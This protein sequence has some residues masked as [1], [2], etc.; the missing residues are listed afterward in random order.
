M[1]V[2][3]KQFPRGRGKGPLHRLLLAVMTAVLALGAGGCGRTQE[4]GGERTGLAFT[5][6]DLEKV[7]QELSAIIE[8]NK[9]KEIRMT[10]RDQEVLYLIRGY[11]EQAT[12]GYSI[13]VVECSE[14]EE[15]I[16]FD[17]RLIGPKSQEELPKAP[18]YPCLVVKI[19]AREKEV[20]IE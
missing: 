18:S 11:G 2:M 7:P 15:H 13:E 6:V 20:M 8:K 10:Y 19:E 5:V 1:S 14:D 9:Q 4:S 16:W 17:T 3:R 12:G